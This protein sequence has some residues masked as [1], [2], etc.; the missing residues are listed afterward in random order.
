[1]HMNFQSYPIE[2]VIE[3]EILRH[4]AAIAAWIS[5]TLPEES[6]DAT[7]ADALHRN[8]EWVRPTGEEQSRDEILTWV[9]GRRG[10]HPG[11]RLLLED[12][13]LIAHEGNIAVVKYT[14]M[15][16]YPPADMPK[17]NRRATAVFMLEPRVRWLHLFE[18]FRP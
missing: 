2:D 18:T 8:F 7:F 15:G 16:L 4:H 17:N 13:Q 9:R 12:F 3:S 6:F 10:I 14:E 1:M 5:G 11:A